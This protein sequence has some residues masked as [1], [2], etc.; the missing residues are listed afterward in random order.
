MHIFVLYFAVSKDPW[1]YRANKIM[2]YDI[3]LICFSS[4]TYHFYSTPF[5]IPVVFYYLM[6]FHIFK[7]I[8]D[9]KAVLWHIDL[10]L[11]PL[12][13]SLDAQVNTA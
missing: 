13:P 9:F 4:L 2:S 11:C 1:A 6:G 5:D 3:A 7:I 10:I 8:E 12:D